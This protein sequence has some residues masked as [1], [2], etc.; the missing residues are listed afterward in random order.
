MR[1]EET[2]KNSLAMHRKIPRK[3]P[4]STGGINCFEEKVLSVKQYRIISAGSAS[5]K[6][7]YI[8]STV[9]LFNIFFNNMHNDLRVCVHKNGIKQTGIMHYKNCN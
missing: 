4:V 1:L 2:K 9:Y 5:S 6:N 8:T 3:S 7:A